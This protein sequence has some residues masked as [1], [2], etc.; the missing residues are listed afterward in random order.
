MVYLLDPTDRVEAAVA[1]PYT[2]VIRHDPSDGGYSA[3]VLELPGVFGGGETA[4]EANDSLD[5]SIRLWVAHEIAAGHEIPAPFD[6][7]GFSGRV[8]LR[9][10][11]FLHER[12]QVRAAIERVSL[13]RLLEVAIGAY[14]GERVEPSPRGVADRLRVA[15]E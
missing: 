10:T 13:N 6:P 5:E 7:E 9:M 4:Q 12:A 3:Y 1:A 11:P 8:T 2:R 15:E 14:L